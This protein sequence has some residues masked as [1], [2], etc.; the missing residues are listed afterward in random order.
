MRIG[1]DGRSITDPPTGVGNYLLSILKEFLKRKIQC[2]L[3]VEDITKPLSTIKTPYLEIVKIPF[4]PSLVRHER[5]YEWEENRLPVYIQKTKIDL[6]HAPDSAGIPKNLS[7]PKVLTV[8]DL[9][10]YIMPDLPDRD[11]NQ[12]KF[13][14]K[15][16]KNAVKRANK[17]I[18]IS[19]TTKHDLENLLKVASNKI[20]VIHQ[21]VGI[22]RKVNSQAI[23]EIKKRFK[24]NRDYIIY[25]GGLAERKNVD[26]LIQSF[27]LLR[28]KFDLQLV[29][30]GKIIPSF[31][32][33][34]KI[35]QKE[36]LKNS[37]IFILKYIPEK[38]LSI[39][40]QGARALVFIS[41]YEGFGLPVLEGFQAEIPVILSKIP[42][43]LEIAKDAAYYI[44]DYLDPSSIAKGIEEVL[45]NK[46]LRKSL[47]K[48]GKERVKNFSWEK[49]AQKT[50]SVY[51]SLIKE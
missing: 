14:E 46:R 31:K 47:M 41:S 37:I 44:D 13:Y 1:L 48:R 30:V 36:N 21:G 49:T 9:I 5:R 43:F 39:L 19:Y 34:E 38:D 2:V 12:F 20:T 42:V 29:I 28:Y 4:N 15:R 50:I 51:Q 17:I 8:H 33:L 10:P 32:K 7:I 35:I 24:I 16:I 40:L 6:Y 27:S 22:F 18:A 26:K 45:T 23:N 3:F 25:N 11:P